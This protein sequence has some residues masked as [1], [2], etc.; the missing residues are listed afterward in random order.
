MTTALTEKVYQSARTAIKAQKTVK[1]LPVSAHMLVQT[2][3]G[4]IYITPFNLEQTHE[5]RTKSTVRVPARV[6]NEFQTCVPAKKFTA[7]MYATL[8][9]KEEKRR[10]Q[11]A[12]VRFQ[13]C[14]IT[15]NLT[16]QSG[17]SRATFKC[18]DAQNFLPVEIKQ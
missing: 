18:M 2:V 16:I 10:N 5:E 8:P 17:N 12:T 15:Q 11:G 13:F 9:T 7:W 3:E 6:E 4:C 14:P 1:S